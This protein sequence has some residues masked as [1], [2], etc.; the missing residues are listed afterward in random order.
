MDKTEI[1]EQIKGI[2]DSSET[3]VLVQADNPDADSLASSLA[4]EEILAEKGKNVILYCGVDIPSYLHYMQ[5]W[6]RVTKDFPS[7]FDCAIIIDT[8]TVT[9]LEQLDKSG[10]LGWLAS[11]PVIILDHHSTEPTISFAK[12]I[13]N[14]KAVATGEVIYELASRLQWQMNDEAKKLIAIAILSDSLGLMSQST[15]ARSIHI[16]AELVEAGVNLPEIES[17]RRESMKREPE[18]VHYKGEL[19]KRIEFYDN[20]RVAVVDIPWS[21]IEKYSPLYN[22]PMLVID[23]MRLGKNTQIAICFK[24]YTD[25]K[26]TAKM[27]SN[28]GYPI[29]AELAESFGGGGHPYA[30]GFK[31]TDVQNFSEL[32]SKVIQTASELLDKSESELKK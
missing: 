14:D 26:V 16:I 22:P 18:L 28:Y 7:N 12:V 17:T 20:N 21:E 3:V 15:S 9:L 2:I 23:D 13:L 24:I 27:R 11:K 31:V 19:L 29:C 25:K 32:K 1:Y 10:S 4:L 5:G 8:S 30:S 6:S